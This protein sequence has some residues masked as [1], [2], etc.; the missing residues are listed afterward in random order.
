VFLAARRWPIR[1]PWI[2]LRIALYALGGVMVA[3]LH[4]LLLQ[5]VTNPQSPFLTLVYPGGV[6]VA[7]A[8]V[9]VLVAIGHRRQLADWLR[10]REL[11]DAML[12]AEVRSAR[13]RAERLHE[14]SPVLLR[15]LERIAEVVQLEPRRTEELLARLADYLRAAI[16]CSDELGVT[17]ERERV[18]SYCVARVEESGGFVLQPHASA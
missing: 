15:A 12:G 8:I 3:I 6:V 16:E 2:G 17:P 18:L 14:V 7:L 13:A 1:Q 5:R 11:A 9:V 4:P 10:T